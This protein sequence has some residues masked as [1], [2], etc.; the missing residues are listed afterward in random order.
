VLN[1]FIVELRVILRRVAPEYYRLFPNAGKPCHTCAFNPATDDWRGSETTANTLMQCLRDDQPFH[2]HEGI[3]WTKPVEEWTAE[4]IQHYMRN[5]KLCAG[6]AIV[7]S[8]V[9]N[10]NRD[11]KLAFLR[12]AVKADAKDLASA[13]IPGAGDVFARLEKKLKDAN[14]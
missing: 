4:E 6:Y 2:C 5:R 9:G 7:S 8:T 14:V 11:A 3:P 10:A 1:A 13:C 12:G